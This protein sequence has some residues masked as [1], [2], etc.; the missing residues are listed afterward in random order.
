MLLGPPRDRRA[1]ALTRGKNILE[2]DVMRSA[3]AE[4]EA[5]MF[6]LVVGR[7]LVSCWKLSRGRRESMVLKWESVKSCHG[8]RLRTSHQKCE[9]VP[10]EG[11][12]E[13]WRTR[14]MG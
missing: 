2:M 3:S 11:P 8:R 14:L 5:V 10:R 7:E 9:T 12:G 1:A 4:G 13:R 6:G